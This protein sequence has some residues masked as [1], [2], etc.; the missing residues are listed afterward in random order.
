MLYLQQDCSLLL[1]GINMCHVKPEQL[2]TAITRLRHIAL[3]NA[4]VN[5][6]IMTTIQINLLFS[7][8]LLTN[9]LKQVD[10]STVYLGDVDPQDLAK[11]IAQ[12]EKA[13]FR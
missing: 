1:Y 7:H 9:R 2:T 10:L 4:E 5:T 13:Q 8:F 12:F 6:Q 3:G 11:S